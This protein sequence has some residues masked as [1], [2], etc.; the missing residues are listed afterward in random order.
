[1][2][3]AVQSILNDK[4]FDDVVGIN[5]SELRDVASTFNVA[6]LIEPEYESGF[7]NEAAMA[8]L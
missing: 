7:N 5:V 3:R 2:N 8:A 6:H 4:E 1:M